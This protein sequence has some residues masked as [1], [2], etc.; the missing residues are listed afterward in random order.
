VPFQ[1]VAHV[2]DD[3]SSKIKDRLCRFVGNLCTLNPLCVLLPERF[4]VCHSV[5]QNL[6]ADPQLNTERLITRNCRL[7]IAM[8]EVPFDV[9]SSKVQPFITLLD[10]CAVP[11]DISN[12]ST[13][14]LQLAGSLQSSMLQLLRWVSTV[15]CSSLTRK[16]LA[17]SIITSWA[18]SGVDITHSVLLAL[19]NLDN[20][21]DTNTGIIGSIVAELARSNILDPAI[22]LRWVIAT[23]AISKSSCDTRVSPSQYMFQAQLT[24]VVDIVRATDRA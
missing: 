13:H 2:T 12:I 11:Y 15:Y 19:P 10:S 23:G 9:S 20:L 17:L 1:L 21:L 24:E 4:S 5:L 16:Y 6:P 18:A 22:V 3:A 14:C 7:A 8:N